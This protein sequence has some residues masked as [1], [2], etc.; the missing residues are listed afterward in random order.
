MKSKAANANQ[1]GVGVI[2]PLSDAVTDMLTKTFKAGG[3]A[4]AILGLGA[5]FMLAA[6]FL[7]RPNPVRFAVLGV[8][9]SL[10]FFTIFYVYIKE[11]RPESEAREPLRRNK[12]MLD[13]IQR[14]GLE[15]TALV[16]DLQSLAFKNANQV[17]QVL[18]PLRP[19]LQSLSLEYKLGATDSIIQ[20]D[21]ISKTI[22]DSADKINSVITGLQQALSESNPVPLKGYL[23]DLHEYRELVRTMLKH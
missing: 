12:D 18:T 6:F 22:M 4:L 1:S 11:L 19:Y 21:N 14:I 9:V 7:D 2:K 15:L 8:G 5:L 10:E 17:S 16:G 3:F 20:V 13:A 23:D